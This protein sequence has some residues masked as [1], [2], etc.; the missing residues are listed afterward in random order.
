MSE[1]S[2]K[3]F[4]EDMGRIVCRHMINHIMFNKVDERAFDDNRLGQRDLMNYL[5]DL[6]DTL[7][8]KL[9]LV[10]LGSDVEQCRTDFVLPQEPKIPLHMS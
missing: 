8:E 2:A 9:L 4:D 3:H 5:Y 7:E 10:E 1:P 6:I